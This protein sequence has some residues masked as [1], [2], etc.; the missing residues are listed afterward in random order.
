MSRGEPYGPEMAISP[1]M[2]EVAGFIGGETYH[3]DMTMP[4]REAKG[5]V[6]ASLGGRPDSGCE[7]GETG[8]RAQACPA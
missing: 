8:P 4:A 5:K 3:D 2:D 1:I 6:K 7:H